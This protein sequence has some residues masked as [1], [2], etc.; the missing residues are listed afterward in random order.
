[1]ENKNKSL[2]YIKKLIKLARENQVEWI[3]VD[4]VEFKVSMMGLVDYQSI[5]KANNNGSVANL[6]HSITP[7]NAH[8]GDDEDLFYSVE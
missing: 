1:M 6:T 8:N 7:E 3:K 2:V 5:G 4:G